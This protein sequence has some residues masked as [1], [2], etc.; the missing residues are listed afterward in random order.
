[1]FKNFTQSMM[2]KLSHTNVYNWFLKKVFPKIR[3]STYYTSMRGWKYQDGHRLLRKGDI[4]VTLDNNKASTVMIGGEWAHAGL[5]IGLE[6]HGDNYECAEM[7]SKNF[8]WSHFA[9]MCFEAD[10]VA[11]YRCTDWDEYYIEEVIKKCLSLKDA[12]YDNQFEAA[13]SE[14][15]CSELI[16]VADFEKRLHLPKE[17]LEIIGLDYVSPTGI[18]K[19]DNVELIW[20]SDNAVPPEKK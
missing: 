9:D 16:A 7:T 1:M 12:H 14:L 5:C 10:K 3:F 13:D 18:T 20:H 11:I 19:A 4:I 6:S 8:T 15:Y 17:R 2:R